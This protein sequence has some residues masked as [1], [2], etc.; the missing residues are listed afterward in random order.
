MSCF[1]NFNN[2]FNAY[3]WISFFFKRRTDQVANHSEN[4]KLESLWQKIGKSRKKHKKQKTVN[5]N[6]NQDK[7][8][9]K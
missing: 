4:K 8:N 6:K 9:L 3:N 2:N 5:K 7:D 1:I